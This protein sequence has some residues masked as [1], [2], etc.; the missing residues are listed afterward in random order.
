MFSNQD[1]KLYDVLGVS[2]DASE[3]VIKK[4]YRKKAMKYHPDRNLNDKENSEK[5][6]KEISHAYEILSDKGKRDTYDRFGLDG[7]NNS[8]SA[9]FDGGNP[10]DMF[11]NI[12]NSSNGFENVFNMNT[13][14]RNNTKKAQRSKNIVKELDVKLEDIYCKKQF[15]VSF[16]KNIICQ[17]CSGLGVKDKSFIK[18]CA[19]CDGTGVIIS[20]KTMGP[21]FISQ[22][23]TTCNQCNGAGK[24]TD[25]SGICKKCDGSK[26]E[27][28][29]RV[30]NVKLNHSHKNGD[31]IVISGE[32]HESVDALLCGDLILILL[33][34]PHSSFER[35]GN[36]LIYKKQITLVE[37]ICGSD[38]I[39]K[40]LDKRQILSKTG[41]IISPGT[42]KKIN[43]EGFNGGD[44]II[45]F[46]IVFPKKLSKDRKEYI[47][48]LIP[49][50]KKK[51]IDYSN[52][53]L[54]ILEDCKEKFEK[55]NYKLDEEVEDEPSIA[56][57]QQ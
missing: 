32:S 22:S 51:V 35:N 13:N 5:K 46:D 7:I 36:N 37:A 17:K 39:I 26:Y 12:F 44:I 57:A 28:V 40:H 33:V 9:G 52:Y 8:G 19:K 43:G 27:K 1:T 4:S 49:Q 30:I 38:I 34:K 41:D 56:C 3:E 24:E 45:E 10:F 21:G 42:L 15:N 55:T 16:E 6:F 2:K 11:S 47:S 14:K 20:V 29:K 53:E 48:K 54:K 50:S 31:K 23:Q 18:T 25:Y